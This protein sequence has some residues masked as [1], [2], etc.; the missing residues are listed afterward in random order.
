MQILPISTISTNYSARHNQNGNGAEN[1]NF[2]NMTGALSKKIYKNAYSTISI[3]REQES[4]I[5]GLVGELPEII[6]MKLTPQNFESGRREILAAFDQVANLIRHHSR[7]SISDW[8]KINAYKKQDFTDFYRPT[9]AEDLLNA[10]FHKYDVIPKWDDVELRYINRKGHSSK[11][12]QIVGLHD[13][14]RNND[15]D[16]LLKVYDTTTGDCYGELNAAQYWMTN[17]G[18]DTQKGKFYCGN[19]DSGYMLT[20]YIDEDCRRPAR[21]ISPYAYGLDY[22][23][24]KEYDVLPNDM[25]LIEGFTKDKMT[26]HNIEAKRVKGYNYRWNG[27]VVVNKIKHEFPVAR[28]YMENVRDH[29]PAKMMDYWNEQMKTLDPLRMEDEDKLAGLAMGIKYLVKQGYPYAAPIEKCLSLNNDKV[30]QALCYVL[31]YLPERDAKYY[32]EVLAQRENPETQS[33]LFDEIALL[34]K[35]KDKDVPVR[36]DINVALRDIVPS[37]LKAYCEI[38]SD[39]CLPENRTKLRRMITISWY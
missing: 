36:D 15:D 35:R 32:F 12:F 37:K 7:Q 6:T 39:H 38:A 29:D 8:D 3:M 13:S 31:K 25:E 18:R 14:L 23:R 21:W 30:D 10:V 24:T 2:K 19:L 22:D 20:K 16:F 17:V 27:M 11:G 34:A 26:T 1:V 33:I 5:K 9:E 28:E 4:G